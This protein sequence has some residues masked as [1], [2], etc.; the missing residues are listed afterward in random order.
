MI[1]ENPELAMNNEIDSN[2][3]DLILYINYGLKT[4]KLIVIITNISYFAGCIWLIIC[5]LTVD[6][7]TAID[8]NSDTDHFMSYFKMNEKS[9]TEQII[10][11]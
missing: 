3:I 1:I 6:F 10:I 11:V 4:L 2:N 8:W 7:S 5:E 9:H